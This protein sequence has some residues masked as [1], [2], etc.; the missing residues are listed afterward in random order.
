[1]K[2]VEFLL[3]APLLLASCM[4]PQSG[5]PWMDN[6]NQPRSAA[7]P[8][9]ARDFIIRRQGCDHFRGEYGGEG[10]ERQKIINSQITELCTGTDAELSRLRTKYAGR[11]ETIRALAEFEDCIEYD[12]V[13]S[14]QE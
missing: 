2:R 3:V 1:M 11:A 14:K 5:E 7:I 10:T 4:A 6:Y 13:C 12:T 8:Q 9:D